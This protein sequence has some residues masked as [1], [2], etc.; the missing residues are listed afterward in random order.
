MDEPDYDKLLKMAVKAKKDQTEVWREVAKTQ[1]ALAARV[2]P[3]GV[4][5]YAAN[6]GVWY[7]AVGLVDLNANSPER[8]KS[9]GLDILNANDRAVLTSRLDSPLASQR[10]ANS[11]PRARYGSCLL[12]VL[13]SE[14]TWH[15]L[16]RCS[17]ASLRT[18]RALSSR[19]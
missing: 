5:A 8:L 18:S 3:S 16:S 13:A 14:R 10:G 12:A 2:E 19:A 4:A 11:V 1:E 17:E 6:R 9:F 7:E 15:A